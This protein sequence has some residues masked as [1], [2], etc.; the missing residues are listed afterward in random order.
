MTVRVERSA[1]A[2]RT[3]EARV[4]VRARFH[5]DELIVTAVGDDGHS[6]AAAQPGDAP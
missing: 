4:L 3:H 2:S 1:H 5:G 6:Y